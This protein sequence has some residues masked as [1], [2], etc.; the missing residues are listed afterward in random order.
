MDLISVAHT[1][2]SLVTTIAMNNR[3]KIDGSYYLIYKEI[4]PATVQLLQENGITVVHEAALG[5]LVAYDR[6]RNL[7]LPELRHRTGWYLQQF[8]QMAGAI[9]QSTADE[10][11][12]AGSDTFMTDRFCAKT[13]DNKKYLSVIPHIKRNWDATIE[14]LG[15]FADDPLHC[16][17]VEH[18]VTDRRVL[19]TIFRHYSSSGVALDEAFRQF[20]VSVLTTVNIT[21]QE[22]DRYYAETGALI[23]EPAMLDDL[24]S[25]Y[26]FI[27]LFMMNN[28]G[29]DVVLRNISHSRHF[30]Q[31]NLLV[32]RRKPSG[33][34]VLAME[35]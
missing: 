28:F 33:Y 7:L 21:R 26:Q 19:E 13:P 9:F 1:V 24:F 3:Q 2:D 11:I 22:V 30:Q 5:N 12:L 25:E 10:M 6:V 14:K 20:V 17:V 16:F 18:V 15:L 35:Y 23:N 29:S 4:N 34:E 8:L 32:N 31:R 27:S